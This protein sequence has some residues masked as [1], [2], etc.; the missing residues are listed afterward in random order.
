MACRGRP[1][2]S[3]HLSAARYCH[4]LRLKATLAPLAVLWTPTP[5]LRIYGVI[6]RFSSRLTARWE[7]SN[8]CDDEIH[9]QEGRLVGK[10]KVATSVAHRG[11]RSNS[12]R[13]HWTQRVCIWRGVGGTAS[14]HVTLHVGGIGPC[15]CSVQ[16]RS[17]LSGM[18]MRR[19]IFDTFS[20]VVVWPARSPRVTGGKP[21]P[22]SLIPPTWTGERPLNSGRPNV[23]RPSPPYVSPRIENRAV[24]CEIARSWPLQNAQPRGAKLPPNIIIWPINGSKMQSLFGLFLC[25]ISH[26]S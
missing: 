4:C 3:G 11:L 26:T 16:Y 21:G 6:S 8:Q 1:G 25:R 15:R 10:W 24:F 18:C 22:A 23:V 12:L 17:C 9:A 14:K 7:C 2:R 20:V 5:L 13:S 19:E